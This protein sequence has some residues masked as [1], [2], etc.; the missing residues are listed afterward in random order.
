MKRMFA[1]VALVLVLAATVYAQAPKSSG[2]CDSACC[3]SSCCK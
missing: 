3:D 2:C 1:S